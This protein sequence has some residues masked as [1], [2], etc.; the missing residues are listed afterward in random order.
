MHPPGSA[1]RETRV[2]SEQRISLQNVSACRTRGIVTARDREIQ[3]MEAGFG[4]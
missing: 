2:L 1:V 3:Y 4:S